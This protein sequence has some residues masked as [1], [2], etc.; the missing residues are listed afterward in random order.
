[1]T[2]CYYLSFLDVNE[3]I[4]SEFILLQSIL[5][6]VR[7]CLKEGRYLLQFSFVFLS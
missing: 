1:M 5:L 4:N 2:F 3:K 6:L 7:L